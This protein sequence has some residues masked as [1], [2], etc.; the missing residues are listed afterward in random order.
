M[1]QLIDSVRATTP[2]ALPRIAEEW[3]I[4]A[5]AEH[6]AAAAASALTILGENRLGNELIKYSRHFVEG[7]IARMAKD[8]V[9]A[10]AAFDAA[11]AEQEKLV[12]AHPDDA[13][14]LCVL[15]LIDAALGRKEEALARGPARS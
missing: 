3:L 11:R 9:K 2:D 10:H 4:C 13:G 7:L 8:D 6:D 5:L 14:A 12:G 1:H 15:G